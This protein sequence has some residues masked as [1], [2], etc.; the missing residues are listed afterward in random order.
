MARDT[1]SYLNPDCVADPSHQHHT[2]DVPVRVSGQ[3]YGAIEGGGLLQ[4]ERPWLQRD[5]RA[6]R[7]GLGW[8]HRGDLATDDAEALWR[9][10]QSY[11]EMFSDRGAFDS[12]DEQTH[13]EGVACLRD[14]ARL[15]AT[16]DQLARQS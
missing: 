2:H 10:L 11:G 15:R 16:L 9:T 7:V 4:Q 12:D 8:Q 14:A 6:V 1:D 5:L 13:R 3:A